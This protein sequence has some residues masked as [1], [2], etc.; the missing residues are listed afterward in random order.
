MRSSSFCSS[1]A[2]QTWTS[3]SGASQHALMLPAE[4]GLAQLHP[5]LV[6]FC[7]LTLQS[8][9]CRREDP[10]LQQAATALEAAVDE[11]IGIAYA[12]PQQAQTGEMQ[13]QL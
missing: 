8:S 7:Y 11:A 10:A 2:R 12:T 1:C 6:I 9:S 3:G 4:A 13:C 5:L